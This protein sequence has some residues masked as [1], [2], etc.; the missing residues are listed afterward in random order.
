MD[1]KINVSVMFLKNAEKV[2]DTLKKMY[3][4]WQN[5]SRVTNLYEKLLSEGQEGRSL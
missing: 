4:N 2:Y 3:S 5:I 1:E